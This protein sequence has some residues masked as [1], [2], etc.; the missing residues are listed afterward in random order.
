[1]SVARLII[2]DARQAIQALPDRSVDL[3]VT[4]PPYLGQRRYLPNGDPNALLELGQE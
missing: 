4:S 3:V 2:G 1:M